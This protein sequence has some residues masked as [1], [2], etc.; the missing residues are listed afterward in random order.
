MDYSLGQ[1]T[2]ARELREVS[3]DLRSGQEVDTVQPTVEPA[4]AHWEGADIN[5]EDSSD[6]SDLDLPARDDSE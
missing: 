1:D 6:E 5:G 2:D 3:M 4:Q